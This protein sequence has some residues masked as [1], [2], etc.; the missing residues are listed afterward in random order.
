MRKARCFRYISAAPVAKCDVFKNP[1]GSSRVGR[2]SGRHVLIFKKNIRL[3]R[4]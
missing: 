2:P 3:C 4:E 1:D